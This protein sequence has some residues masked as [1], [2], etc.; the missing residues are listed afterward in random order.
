MTALA[1]PPAGEHP[2]PGPSSPRGARTTDEMPAA[3][4]V[5]QPRAAGTRSATPTPAP[6]LT[7]PYWH[8]H[9]VTSIFDHCNPDYSQDGK[10]CEFDGTVAL[11]T[12]GADA[13]F[14][15]GYAITPKGSDYLYYD[16]HNGWDYAL[17]Y[18]PVVAAAAGTVQ[19]AGVDGGFGLSVT[20]DHGN[21][22]GTRYAHLSQITVSPGEQVGRGQG[23]GTSG[24]TGNSS[25]P[26]LH[27]G[28][29]L[30]PSWTAIDP[31]GWTG[32][33][34]D[35]WPSDTG[36]L[37]IGGAPHDA[38]P[39]T[40]TGVSATVSG[41]SVTVKWAPGGP[42]GG[43]ATSYTV[44]SSPASESVVVS[45]KATSATLSCL[46]NPNSFTFTV[47]PV[48]GGGTGAPSAP[49]NRVTTSTPSAQ[50][51]G[52]GVTGGY[53]ILNSAGAIY[54][55]C[56]GAYFG[57]LLDHG[58]PGPAVGVATTPAGAGYNILT[59]AGLLY[60]FGN[61]QYYGNL[62]D[63]GYPGPASALAFTPSGGGYA[64]LTSA[65]LLYT[66]GD[67]LYW[68]N[69]LDH[70]YP[71]TAV[72]LAYTPSGRG[73]YILTREGAIYSFGDAGYF[74]NLLDHGYPGEAK[75]ISNTRDGRGYAIMT[76]DGTLYPFGDQPYF[77]SLLDHGYPGPAEAVSNTP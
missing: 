75:S 63:H 59:H 23:L 25:G 9:T 62:L 52:P 45:G 56:R 24:N 72:G 48:N 5:A 54:T 1:G 77:G 32:D 68:G 6:F 14:N 65:G 60:S 29:Y 39:S 64:T 44:S 47:T 21:G 42:D 41:N 10:V 20:I 67:A 11:K 28:V 55:F 36:N 35:P 70:H 53:T 31:W 43:T 69:L 38:G 19:T 26:H 16:G 37:W 8:A 76:T 73:Y 18:E 46:P 13:S 40:P 74:G 17:S 7:R 4:H 71:G 51:S 33:G 15:R 61:A 3:N 58:Y 49:S 34:T 2:L 22:Y 27:F 57:N 12:S 50:P 30:L 66:F